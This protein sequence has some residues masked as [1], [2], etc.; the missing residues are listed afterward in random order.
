MKEIEGNKR[1]TG[2]K[3][4][5]AHS[6]NGGSPNQPSMFP[7]PHTSTIRTPQKSQENDEPLFF[8]DSLRFFRLPAGRRPK[9]D[10]VGFLCLSLH[11]LWWAGFARART[12]IRVPHSRMILFIHRVHFSLSQSSSSTVLMCLS[13]GLSL[14]YL[15]GLGGFCL[16]TKLL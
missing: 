9:D 8:L 12:T 13:G 4:L 11:S 5:E 15:G 2:P 10:K 7:S 1:G 6:F 3:R 16:I 14:G